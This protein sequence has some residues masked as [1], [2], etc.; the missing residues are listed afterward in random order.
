[1]IKSF[2][3]TVNAMTFKFNSFT[4]EFSGYNL[5]QIFILK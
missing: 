5:I 2:T 3:D 1:M 4:I